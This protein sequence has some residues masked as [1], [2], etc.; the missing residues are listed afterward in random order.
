[1]KK[2]DLQA[3]VTYK[4]LVILSLAALL[5]R[6][7]FA[8]LTRHTIHSAEDFLIAQNLV[9]GLGYTFDINVGATALKAP[10]YPLFLAGII[11]VFEQHAP[12]VAAIIQHCLLGIVP[13][14]LARFARE[15]KAEKLGLLTGFLF[16]IHPTY[17]YYPNVLEV[18]NLFVPLS[19]GWGILSVL[20]WRSSSVKYGVMWGITSGI[21]ILTQPLSLPFVGVLCCAFAYKRTYKILFVSLVACALVFAPWVTRNYIVFHKLIPTK[22]AFWMNFYVGWLP[23][24]HGR[25]E[26]ACLPDSTRH[27]IDSLVQIKN[28][29]ELE[30]EYK[31]AFLTTVAHNPSLFAQKIIWQ[32]GVFWWIPNRYSSDTSLGFLIVR[33]LPVIV[34]NFAWCLSVVFIYKHHKR[35]A[36]LSI[37]ALLYFTCIYALTQT[38]NIRFKLD[39][40]WIELFAVA[41]FIHYLLYNDKQLTPQK[42]TA[43]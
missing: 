17:F 24:N 34:L 1:M 30:P 35:L 20:M 2:I 42:D 9:S 13:L 32:A 33:K 43:L 14:L 6:L 40:E 5:L 22:S 3:Y 18:T 10:I 41:A 11:T 8:V 16:L 23:Q 36:L 21:M 38:A 19:L 28:D 26:F 37:M 15:C 7:I 31:S 27:R 39:I 4:N 29:V 12:L 25:S